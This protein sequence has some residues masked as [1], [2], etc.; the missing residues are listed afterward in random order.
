MGVVMER[1]NISERYESNRE[2]ETNDSLTTWRELI[3]VEMEKR[4]ETWNDIEA[5]YPEDL[6]LDRRFDDSYGCIE[7]EPFVLWT[8]NRVYFPCR[9]DGS[10]WVESVERNPGRVTDIKHFGGGG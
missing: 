6:D 2:P 4:V 3:S 7:G 5:C 8:K 9:Y 10:E 1:K